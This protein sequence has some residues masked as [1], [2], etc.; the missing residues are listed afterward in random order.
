MAAMN[1]ADTN[2]D[3]AALDRLPETVCER[4]LFVDSGEFD[5]AM[6]DALESIGRSIKASRCSLFLFDASSGKIQL[7]NQWCADGVPANP[8]ELINTDVATHY[9]WLLRKLLAA[10][11]VKL[12]HLGE[13][14]EEASTDRAVLRAQGV[15]SLLLLPMF[16]GEQPLGV[17]GVDTVDQNRMWSRR[18][19]ELLESVR[20]LL[21]HALLRFRAE[22]RASRLEQHYQQLIE[23][24]QAIVYAFD[25]DGRYTFVSPSVTALTGYRAEE[26]IGRSYTEFVHPDDVDRLA[27]EVRS[28][29]IKNQS[30]PPLE[31]R[32]R[33]RDGRIR[34]HRSV[35]APVRDRNGRLE[36]VMANALDITDLRQEAQLRELLLELATRFINL[37][38]DDHDEAINDALARIGHF[39]DADRAYVF[40]YD[41]QANA[42]RNTHEWC[43]NGINPQL[44]SLQAVP[45]DQMPGWLATHRTGQHVLIKDVA[46]HQELWLKELLESQDIKSLLT[47]PMLHDNECIGFVG[48]DSVRTLK[49]YSDTDIHL[50][51]VFAEILVNLHRRHLSQR[52]L[53]DLARR[54]GQI[55]S[56]T[57]AGTWEWNQQTRQM[58]FNQRWAEML[59]YASVAELPSDS[60]EW[61]EWVHP[62][63]FHSAIA[64]LKQ[65]L[66]GLTDHHE[67]E[68][69]V[70]HRD[71]HWI[72]L[73]LRGQ[74]ASRTT[75]G[76]AEMVSGIAL[77]I[78]ERKMA[79][80]RLKESEHRF[81]HL[82]EDV[83][84]LAVTGFDT[85]LKI[86][87]W[88]RFSE[89]LYGWE[90]E[91]VI[92][93]SLLELM[94]PDKHHQQYVASLQSLI[95]GQRSQWSEEM[96]LLDREGREVAVYASHVIQVDVHGRQDI[97]RI[98]IDQ[99]EN[100]AA[101]E[102][103]KLLAS[104]F[105]HSH[106]GILI[107]DPDG[108][109]VEVNE[110]F[111]NITGYQ[112]FEAIGRN[113]RF[114]Q[115]GRQGDEFYSE[116]W[117]TLLRDGFWSGEVWNRRKTGEFYAENLTISAV[118]DARG[119][120]VRY[121]GLFFDITHIKEYQQDL[122]QAAH[123]DALTGLPNR[124]LLTDRLSQ[125]LGRADRHGK[126]VV[127]AYIDI[128]GF[129]VINDQFGHAHGDECLRQISERL[130]QTIR[131]SDTV[132]RLGGDEFVL[133]LTGA[134]NNDEAA[135]ILERVL[136]T[137]ARPC[138]MG[139]AEISMTVS[140]GATTYP[141]AHDTEADQL[142][143]QA[144]QAMYQA[145]T[146][147][148][149]RI[150]FFDAEL[151]HAHA[152]RVSLLGQLR[153][154]LERD[155]LLLHYQPK[156]N[157]LD[158]R[159]I[160]V[161]ALIRWQHPERGL[162][163][164][165]EFLPALEGDELAHAVGKWVMDRS[166]ADLAGWH[167]KGLKIELSFNVSA[168]QLLRAG[169]AEALADCLGRYPELGGEQLTLEFLETG[170]LDDIDAGREVTRVCHGMGVNFALDDFGTGF[171][172]LTHLR[173]LP[174]KQIKIDRSFVRD[175]LEDPEDLAIID[176]VINLARAFDLDVL[177][178]GV[179]TTA[180]AQ[181]L[182]RLGCCQCQGFLFARPMPADKV[183]GWV[184][185]WPGTDQL[186]HLEPIDPDLTP[187][188]FGQAELAARQARLQQTL[189]EGETELQAL[190]TPS[191]FQHWLAR[192]ATEQNVVDAAALREIYQ[193]LLAEQDAA[194]R[195]QAAALDEKASEHAHRFAELVATLSTRLQ[196]LLEAGLTDART[197]G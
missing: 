16:I 109:I 34:W 36:R 60:L 161:E 62:H 92:G 58:I 65:H 81:R 153:K 30:T 25:R 9:P 43:A 57:N 114:L 46:C 185:R 99:R 21:V 8:P 152:Q 188:M 87:F 17:F 80:E 93:R 90:S 187:V 53:G 184:S 116:M 94:V 22:R 193:S 167:R 156:I 154:A 27:P 107:T 32:V 28:S 127:V 102:R 144:D 29:L 45:L 89:R 105:S 115:S 54:L 195:A 163:P 5:Q 124:M 11:P 84:G 148:R 3:G 39:V 35:M 82:L 128:D 118:R 63:D 85:D 123:F 191:R 101:R 66:K 166:L 59:G 56:G 68:I 150:H 49:D 137:V 142:L 78:T 168:Q 7:A 160:G 192:A 106:E 42:A 64:S 18:D 13:L 108:N 196:T 110:A 6:A 117:N 75:D 183:E 91:E 165:A 145:K 178:E 157:L 96:T 112:R 44:D 171:S 129:K 130:Q 1:K 169:F 41:F 50:L 37:P 111:T 151:E 19:L 179:E 133:V 55:I 174:L 164:P 100:K 26:V 180:Q 134:G 155:E 131:A 181:A 120:I 10:E 97:F 122:E 73:L 14:P 197:P 173:H 135:G 24:S 12:T 103:L 186:Q 170:I 31:Y 132:A 176:G 121:V 136:D 143:R 51:K 48:F 126:E 182:I 77:D 61:M 4:L 147:G 79:A 146:R 88:N 190:R 194:E 175:M 2:T 15:R 38:L 140:I 172:S 76:R 141:Q 67:S 23:N 162:L 149:N 52:E 177:A 158:N 69:R 83:P 70:R 86:R 98:D 33:A 95:N 74:V 40:R 71:G 72:W 113:P 104:V 20:D 139:D 125:A 119:R 189:A 159:V 138:R 47:V